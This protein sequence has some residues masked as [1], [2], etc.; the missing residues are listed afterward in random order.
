MISKKSMINIK[1]KKKH[2][3]F[4]W[5]IE[6]IHIKIP[7]EILN[8]LKYSPWFNKNLNRGCWWNGCT[9]IWTGAT[10]LGILDARPDARLNLVWLIVSIQNLS[11]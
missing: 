3:T 7:S 5:F 1:Y 10:G 6:L 8:V 2:P 11:S 4:N 9:A